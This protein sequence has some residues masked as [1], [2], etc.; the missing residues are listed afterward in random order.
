MTSVGMIGVG[1]LG[2]KPPEDPEEPKSEKKGK[3][4]GKKKEL[5]NKFISFEMGKVK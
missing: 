3:K 2:G 5:T 1:A 4:K